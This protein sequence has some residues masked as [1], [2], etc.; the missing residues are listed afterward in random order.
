MIVTK[1]SPRPGSTPLVALAVLLAVVILPTRAADGQR[2][3]TPEPEPFRLDGEIDGRDFEYNEESFLHRFS[4]RFRPSRVRNWFRTREGFRGTVGS[5]RSDEFYVFE[6]LRKTIT[7]SEQHHF[8]FR[9]KRDEDFD[10]RYDRTQ[11]GL[12]TRFGSN[13]YANVLG[14]I[15][16]E[17]EEIDP[18]FELVFAG[19][20][21]SGV[22]FAFLPVDFTLNSKSDSD[23]Y[24]TKPYTYFFEGLW[25]GENDVELGVWVNAN[26]H[27]RLDR[28]LEGFDFTY[29]Q[30]AG[31]VH[32]EL[33]VGSEWS[34]RALIGAEA[35]ER[36]RRQHTPG[37]PDERRLTRMHWQSTVE[38]ER[39]VRE[40][41]DVWFGVRYFHLDERDRRPREPLL[42]REIIRRE[43]MIYGGVSWRLSER[44]LFWPGLYVN[45]IDNSEDFPF[46]PAQNDD[47]DGYVGKL[48]FPVEILFGENATITAG[49]GLLVHR[50]KF[51]GANVQ[52]QIPF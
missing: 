16:G 48:S 33:P 14:E 41:V 25:R 19:A 38:A 31:E 35:G 13:W 34:L 30:Y 5:V 32:V 47:D 23:R 18:Q 3:G 6:E 9:H 2:I 15:V 20:R 1:C 22:R 50:L 28:E 10:G 51:G 36:D 52:V 44:V 46:D 49:L 37:A 39:S 26:P 29:D 8:L 21:G 7:L 27:L 40:D 12:G 4:Y 42:D 43:G 11:I 17:K 24:A 45:V